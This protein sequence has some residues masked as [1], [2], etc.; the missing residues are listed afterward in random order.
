MAEKKLGIHYHDDDTDVT[1][2]V[3]SNGK[4]QTIPR[5]QFYQQFPSEPRHG[6][7]EAKWAEFLDN[8]DKAC[9]AFVKKYG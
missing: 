8:N 1:F 3:G 4:R 9:A 2:H 5:Q 6:I 7:K